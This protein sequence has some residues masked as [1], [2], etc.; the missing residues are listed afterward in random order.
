MKLFSFKYFDVYYDEK[1]KLLEYKWKVNSEN[2]TEKEY[3]ESVKQLLGIIKTYEPRFILA[4]IEEQS[5][6]LNE[7]LQDWLEKNIL[8]ELEKYGVE[9]FAVVKSKSLFV[10]LSYQQ[11]F[12]NAMVYVEFFN[13][14]D[15][16]INW[17]IN[18]ELGEK[19]IIK[20]DSI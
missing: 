12:N 20:I 5:F 19:E 9:K 14:K 11:A 1:Y 3:M 10:N 2:M 18:N 7:G 4:N 13:D 16:A 6:I 17:L 8:L 15:A